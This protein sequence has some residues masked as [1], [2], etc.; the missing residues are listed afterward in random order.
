MSTPSKMKVEIWSDIMCP[1]CYIGKRKYEMAVKELGE[2]SLT[3]EWCSYQL[4][5]T[6]PLEKT[7]GIN[8]F[9]YLE[10]KKGMAHAQVLEMFE[11]ITA[12]GKEVGL[13]FNFDKIIVA[14]SMKAHRFLHFTKTK[15]LSNDAEELLFKAHFTDGADIGDTAA[16]VKLGKQLNLDEKEVQEVLES[17]QFSYEVNQDIREGANV[18]VKGVPFFVFDR[19]YGVSGAQSVEVFKETIEKAVREWWKENPSIQMQGTD[20]SSCDTEGNC[21]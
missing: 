2:S 19:K 3:L 21:V 13:Q 11:G 1:F 10:E 4:D 14:N 6:I 15:G 16:L 5:P 20:G 18:G 12:M 8:Y 17:D 7:E 9:T